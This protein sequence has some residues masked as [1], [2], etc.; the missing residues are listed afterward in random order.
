M[1][2]QGDILIRRPI[3]EVFDYVADER[4]E[5]KYNEQMTHAEKV[6]PGPIG[7][8]TQFHSVM[9][10]GSR[11]VDMTIEFTEFERPRRITERTHMSNMEI[12]GAL[13]FEPVAEGTRMRWVWDL[14]PRGLYRFLGPV[15]RWIGDRQER[16][17]WTGLKR[18]LEKASKS[19][20]ST[21]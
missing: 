18:V 14:Q 9:T 21:I 7:V 2:V 6:T 1:R 8:G 13:F 4:N 12:T 17:V 20:A 5:P 11:A 3:E 10:S 16:T 15:V 19:S